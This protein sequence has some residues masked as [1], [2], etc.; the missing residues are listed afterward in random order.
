[1]DQ[2]TH[3]ARAE[4]WRNII[5]ACGQ[6]PAGQSAKKWMDENGICEQSYYHWQRKFR[7]QAYDQ[8]KEKEMLPSV[9]EKAEVSF[10]EI[11][12]S[13]V[14][15]REDIPGVSEVGRTPAA[16]IR[17]SAT[18][19][20]ISNQISE[21]LLSR[22]LR[23]VSNACGCGRDPAGGPCLRNSWPQDGD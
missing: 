1:M 7:Q 6:R 15:G 22:I 5:K 4:Y 10:A 13:P 11:T 9:T 17:T 20:E 3:A 12:Y 19:I 16:V 21:S 23:E 8:M 14:V 2:C 18:S